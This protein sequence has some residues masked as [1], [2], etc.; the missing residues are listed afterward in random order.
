MSISKQQRPFEEESYPTSSKI[1]YYGDRKFTY[2]IIQEGIYPTA[3]ILKYT[4]A[5]NYFPI[6]DNYIIKTTWGQANNSRTI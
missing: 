2:I 1:I 4:E 6:P 5:P 3:T